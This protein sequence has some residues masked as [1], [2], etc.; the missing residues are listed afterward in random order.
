MSTAALTPG[1]LPSFVVDELKYSLKDVSLSLALYGIQVALF[2]GAAAA[3]S[4]KEGRIWI[5]VV[6]VIT[7]FLCSST[8]A[9]SSITTYWLQM[10]GVGGGHG[11]ESTTALDVIEILSDTSYHISYLL[12]DALVV[13]RAWVIWSE[14]KLVR[15]ILIA[16][17]FCTLAGLSVDLVVDLKSWLDD[18]ALN[19]PMIVAMLLTN[20]VATALVGVRV[21]TYR[22]DIAAALGPVT[23]G[24]RVGSLLMLL[25]ESG[26]LYCAIW[27]TIFVL[28]VGVGSMPWSTNILVSGALHLFATAYPTLVILLVT[29]QQH[30]T[31]KSMMANQSSFLPSIQFVAEDATSLQG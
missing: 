20:A 23:F 8:Q 26:L 1:R 31:V 2:V 3:I 27:V 21:W 22:R 15:G 6:S 16:C 19:A 12:G 28:E 29:T 17:M 5:L 18:K 9:A 24:N 7:V 10:P 11:D 4:R 13:W 25:L 14:S 30:L